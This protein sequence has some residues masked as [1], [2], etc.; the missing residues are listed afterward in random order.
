[1][2]VSFLLYDFQPDWGFI[3]PCFVLCDHGHSGTVGEYEPPILTVASF[4]KGDAVLLQRHD[5]AVPLSS[6]INILQ[7]VF[8]FFASYQRQV[9]SVS[10]AGRL[11]AGQPESQG[12]IPSRGK[13][14]FSSLSH[15][16]WS[17]AQPHVHW[18]LGAVSLGVKWQE[19]ESDAHLHQVSRLKFVEQ[20]LHTPLHIFMM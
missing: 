7:A 12:L 11:W 17:C 6:P 1:M 15:P 2:N 9:S 14:F 20:H 18:V 8:I 10:I 13:R 5:Y 19:C 3:V 4:D 16:H